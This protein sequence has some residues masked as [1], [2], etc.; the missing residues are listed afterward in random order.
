ELPRLDLLEVALAEGVEDDL[1]GVLRPR[2][3]RR[4][5][6]VDAEVLGGETLAG[7][8]GLLVAPFRQRRVHPAREAVLGVPLGLPVTDEDQRAHD[9]G[10]PALGVLCVAPTLLVPGEGA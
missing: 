4:V 10:S 8:L 3:R 9:H 6:A 2:Q 1:P 7:P 5:R